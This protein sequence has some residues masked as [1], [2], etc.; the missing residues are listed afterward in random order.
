M[1][2]SIETFAKW[3]SNL[4]KATLVSMVGKCSCSTVTLIC[5][6]LSFIGLFDVL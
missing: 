1:Y 3:L 2:L 6:L 4:F 5:I